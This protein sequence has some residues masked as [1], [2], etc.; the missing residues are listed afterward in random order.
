[1]P[2]NL[3]NS[4][5][6]MCL[7][8]AAGSKH[9][10]ARKA[11]QPSAPLLRAL[12]V[13][14]CEK[15]KTSNESSTLSRALLLR[16]PKTM[17]IMKL[18]GVAQAKSMVRLRPPPTWQRSQNP[19]RLKRSKMSLQENLWGSLRACWPTPQNESKTSLLETL[20]VKT[21]LF[22]DSGDSFLTRFGGSA[23]TLGDSPRD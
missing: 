2:K 6:G 15:R 5:H 23:R 14:Q 3:D 21:H 9:I 22:L 1:M 7:C 12:I 19:P 18:A 20:R 8:K 16:P 13:L 10:H 17:K 11:R 4:V